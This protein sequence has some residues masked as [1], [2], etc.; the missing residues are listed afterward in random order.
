M[1]VKICG[2]T[3]PDDARLAAD[4]GVT[5]IGVVLWPHSR[6]A[7]DARTAN[8]IVRVLP[9]AVLAVGVFVDERCDVVNRIAEEVG[10]HAVQ[11][12]GDES[13]DYC[14]QMTRPVI[15]SIP[16]DDACAAT[17]ADGLPA[18]CTILVDTADRLQRGGTGRVANWHAAAA[19]ARVRRTILAGGLHAGNV[20][21]AIDTVAPYGVDVSSGVE[22]SPGIKDRDRLTAFMRAV[23]AREV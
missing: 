17:L 21:A 3:R 12:H 4:L 20:R 7:V 2:V 19:V 9:P 15:K 5:A 22:A 16:L 1:F 8:R 6:R 23:A 11:L 13:P 18:D 14:R 10:L